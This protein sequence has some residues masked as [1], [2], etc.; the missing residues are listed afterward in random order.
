MTLEDAGVKEGKPHLSTS[1][2]CMHSHNYG[3]A[4][5]NCENTVNYT[6]DYKMNSFHREPYWSNRPWKIFWEMLLYLDHELI[7]NIK[8]YKP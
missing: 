7:E 3:S 4:C 6:L 1:G 8:A 5:F 2:L